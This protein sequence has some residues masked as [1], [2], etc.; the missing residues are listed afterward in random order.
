[1]KVKENPLKSEV[2]G[3]TVDWW[4]RTNHV[5]Q[6]SRSLVQFPSRIVHL[7]LPSCHLQ[8]VNVVDLTPLVLVLLPA[9][10]MQ[11][12]IVSGWRHTEWDHGTSRSKKNWL[13]GPFWKCL[14]KPEEQ[15]GCA[16]WMFTAIFLCNMLFYVYAAQLQC[17]GV[18]YYLG[19]GENPEPFNNCYL[20]DTV[21]STHYLLFRRS[22]VFSVHHPSVG[23]RTC[24]IATVWRFS[25]QLTAGCF[26]TSA[27][28]IM[29][30]Q[31]KSQAWLWWFRMNIDR[32]RA[33]CIARD[34]RFQS[35]SAQMLMCDRLFYND[36][37]GTFLF[38]FFLPQ[39]SSK[40][41]CHHQ[42]VRLFAHSQNTEL[43][44]CQQ[45]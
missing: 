30:A 29:W 19:G 16:I 20:S 44:C 2:R 14:T 26:L 35:L 5:Q 39:G 9:A 12:H 34:G 10:E 38:C 36:F 22:V 15:S 3:Q 18:M 28:L 8:D 6:S 17:T 1:M 21:R 32:W 25:C 4:C 33:R 11:S 37:K 23:F 27:T 13:I 41:H 31:A 40:P 24:L 42:E 43:P 7:R 45:K